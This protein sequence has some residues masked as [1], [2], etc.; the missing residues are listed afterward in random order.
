MDETRH[1]AAQFAF[2]FSGSS[3]GDF[4]VQ[5]FDDNFNSLRMILH[6]QSTW[7]MAAILRQINYLRSHH[8]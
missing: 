6:L 5:V 8:S 2:C 4:G 7:L 1:D 3:D